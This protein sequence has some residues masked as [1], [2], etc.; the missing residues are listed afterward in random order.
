MMYGLSLHN[1]L[2]LKYHPEAPSLYDSDVI[3]RAEDGTENWQDIPTTLKKGYGD[4]ED[5]ACFRI[6][7]HWL[8]G[9]RAMPFVTWRPGATS[10]NTIYHAL[11]RLPN[12]YI[13][14][15]SRALGMNGHPMVRRPVYI[16]KARL[17]T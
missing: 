9:V 8:H 2:W 16:G 13:E 17:I 14:D 3:Y 12:G 15:P 4:C 10:N 7:E 6:A 5:L 1:R 11:V